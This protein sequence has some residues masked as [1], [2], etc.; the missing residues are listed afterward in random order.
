MTATKKN[1]NFVGFRYSPLFFCSK[2]GF[3]FKGGYYALHYDGR[4]LFKGGYY[5][6]H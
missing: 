2:E 1:Y 5:S 6:L 3:L 4:F